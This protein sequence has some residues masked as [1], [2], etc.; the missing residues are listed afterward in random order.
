M[1]HTEMRY[2]G[3]GKEPWRLLFLS[4]LLWMGS[5]SSC[6]NQHCDEPMYCPIGISCL[7]ELNP[8]EK[9][10]LTRLSLLPVGSDTVYANVESGQFYLPLDPASSATQ[11]VWCMLPREYERVEVSTDTL[12]QDGSISEVVFHIGGD[13]L[14]L[15][16]VVGELCLFSDGSLLYYYDGG[17]A[18]PVVDTLKITYDPIHE[19]ISGECGYR[20]SYDLKSVD[21]VRGAGEVVVQGNRVSNKYKENHVNIYMSNY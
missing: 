12:W 11:Y 20:T 17:F 1:Q 18:K 14:I 15:N 13:S 9:C 4:I 8:S 21:F 7:S 19:F 2:S 3:G 6:D 5:L 10:S 16:R